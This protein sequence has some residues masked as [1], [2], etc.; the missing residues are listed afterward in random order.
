MNIAL[1]VLRSISQAIITPPYV[2]VLLMLAFILYTRN[3]RTVIMQ[4][5]IIGEKMN[6]S[7]ELTISQVILGIF[8]GTI[9]SL[10]LSYLGIVFIGQVTVTLLF[11]ISIILMI[12]GNRFIC[13]SYSAGILSLISVS[14]QFIESIYHITIPQLDFLKV[15]VVMIISL[16]AVLH[17]VEGILVIIDGDR[18]TIPVFTN[19]NNTIIGGFALKRYWIIP[20]ALMFIMNNPNIPSGSQASIPMWWPVIKSSSYNLIR[21]AVIGFFA[22]Y[23]MIGYNSITFTKTKKEKVISSGMGI[24]FYGMV[25]L[26][27]AQLG[28]INLGAEFMVAIFAP[29]AHELMLKIQTYIEIN[30]KPKYVSTDDG[31]MVLEVAP[32]SPA[33]EMGIKSG[34][35]LIE[36]NDK[37]IINEQDMMDALGNVSTFIWLKI[38]T[39]HGNLERVDYNK[40]NK[41]KRLGIVFVPRIIPKDSVVM[42]FDRNS[43]QDTLEKVKKDK[44]NKK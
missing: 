32:A 17:I 4:K 29:A 6:S 15:D 35:V 24:S 25:L 1:Y 33:F 28:K 14:I 12:F 20:V 5:M 22:F 43:F 37:K 3:K 26:L 16:V 41:N 31:L 38:K 23:G 7:F 13:F 27:V 11:M 36:I 42:K 9:A 30:G 21:N 18:G 8:A 40:M 10:I 2:F 19:K 44:E 34:D 39:V